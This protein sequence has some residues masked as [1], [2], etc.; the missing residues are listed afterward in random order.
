MKGRSEGSGR[1]A[2]RQEGSMDGRKSEMQVRRDTAKER[3]R[4]ICKREGEGRLEHK[5]KTEGKEAVD[6]RGAQVRVVRGREKQNDGK[7]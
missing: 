5:T 2:G 7:M 4:K 3:G 1:R 6:W